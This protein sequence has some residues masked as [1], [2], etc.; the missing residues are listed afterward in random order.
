MMDL[1]KKIE[2]HQKLRPWGKGLLAHPL[3]QP[4]VNS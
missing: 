2:A 3:N 1:K 4:W